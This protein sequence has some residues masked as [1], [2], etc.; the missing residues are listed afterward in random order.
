MGLLKD[1]QLKAVVDAGAVEGLP[2]VDDWYSKASPVQPAS[3][4]LHVGQ[5]FVPNKELSAT[6]GANTPVTEHVLESGETAIV[7]T[8]ETVHLPSDVAGIGFPPSHVSRD[9]LLMTNPGHVDPGYDGKLHFTLINMA[10][11][12]YV[13]AEGKEIMTLLLFRLDAA[14]HRDYRQRVQ[15]K[16]AAPAGIATAL[17]KLSPDFLNFDER[18]EAVA[19]RVARRESL[20]IQGQQRLIGLISVVVSI[21]VVSAAVSIA[22]KYAAVEANQRLYDERVKA[23]ETQRLVEQ[24]LQAI[25]EQLPKVPPAPKPPK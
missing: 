20:S 17:T 23:A 9:G 18:A 16:G 19:N 14:A 7:A 8:R 4:D 22:Y 10:K 12:R 24:R 11:E 25:E 21:G 13:I 5:I 15:Y 2:P 3:I 6:G 1:D